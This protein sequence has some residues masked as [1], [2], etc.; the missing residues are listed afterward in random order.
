MRKVIIRYLLLTI[1]CALFGAGLSLFIDPNN[2]APG[3]VSGLSILLSRM[4]RLETGTLFLLLNIPIIILGIIK[5]G[6]KF[7]ISTL[8]ATVMV[9]LFTNLLEPIGGLTKEPLLGA[10]AGSVLNAVGMGMVL[11]S[12]ATTGGTDIIVKCLR[13]R[14]PHMKSGAL[15]FMIDIFIVLLSGIVFGR[16]DN[17][18]YSAI[19][20]FTTSMVLDKVLYGTDG[21]KLFFLISDQSDR[22]TARLLAELQIGVTYL[23]GSGAYRQSEKKVVLCAMRKPLI[24]KAERIVREEDDKAFL[25]V[26][27][28][29]EVYGE[30]HKSYFGD[31][32]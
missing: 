29:T 8:Y 21:A 1:Y 7:I 15:F 3:G 27:N 23:K 12:G 13:V 24:P 31:I 16:V 9:S 10:L 17:M 5:F 30:G 32:F 22:I 11:R 4:I 2:L 28:A 6:W 26:A 14:Y 20:V 18:L 19:A 25:I